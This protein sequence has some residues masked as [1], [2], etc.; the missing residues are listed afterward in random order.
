[1]IEIIQGGQPQSG[2]SLLYFYRP[3]LLEQILS[4]IQTGRL[5]SVRVII[6]ENLNLFLFA[7][8]HVRGLA[9]LGKVSECLDSGIRSCF[10][11]YIASY[12]SDTLKF[13]PLIPAPVK[14]A[15]IVRADDAVASNESCHP[16]GALWPFT[17]ERHHLTFVFG[18]EPTDFPRLNS[19]RPKRARHHA[20]TF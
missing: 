2:Y 17:E 18:R 19:S 20:V 10:N 4:A 12:Q 3:A 16:E 8:Q 5:S 6:P 13:G 9:E 14:V 11:Q 7:E 1:Q 15:V